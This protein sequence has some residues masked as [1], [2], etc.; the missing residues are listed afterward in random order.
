MCPETGAPE[1]RLNVSASARQVEKPMA[2]LR[3]LIA[4][5]GTGGHIFPALAVAEELRSRYTI[6]VGS[7]EASR[8]CRIDFLGAGREIERRVIP[9]A[10]FPLNVVRAAGL[11]GIGGWRKVRNLLVLPASFWETGK[12]LRSLRP[13]VVVG[14]GGYVGGPVMLLA[15]IRGIPTI[16][17]E[18]NARPGFTNRALAPFIRVAALGFE[19]AAPFYGSKAQV[20]GHPVRA[21]FN[22]VAAK[23]HT[24]PYTIL[25]LGGSQGSSAINNAVCESLPLFARV[26][27]RV[28]IV[29][30]TGARDAERVL[31]AYQAAGINGCV[32]S[33]IDDVPKSLGETDLV[34]SRSGAST[35]AE[36]AAAGKASLLIPF[37]DAA[38]NHQLA[39]A[40]ALERAGGAQVLEQR[41]LTPQRLFEEAIH[42][43]RPETLRAMEAAARTLAR[44]GAAA[45][46]ADLIE[47]LARKNNQKRQV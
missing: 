42:L 9:A 7:E 30:Q 38:D 31:S 46:I 27:D 44:P 11:K 25:V 2:E 20:T 21:E 37:P 5:G 8:A 18:P 35:V 41:N 47:D 45:R 32:R 43:C 16:L 12:L 1:R 36:L 26:Q 23:D 13:H 14:L 22:R 19:A 3:V 40:Q 29:H 15:A 6:S 39:N 28:R 24:P 4:A 17:I 10:G 33:F 34:I